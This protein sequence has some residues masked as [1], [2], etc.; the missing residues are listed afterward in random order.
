MQ[1]ILEFPA[2]F[3]VGDLLGAKILIQLSNTSLMLISWNMEP[4]TPHVLILIT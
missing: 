2:V 4:E 3:K 1:S